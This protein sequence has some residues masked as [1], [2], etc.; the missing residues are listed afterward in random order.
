M[1]VVTSIRIHANACIE[2][3][4]DI[5]MQLVN[6]KVSVIASLENAQSV[7]RRSVVQR[8]EKHLHTRLMQ[9]LPPGCPP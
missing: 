3:Y 6:E 5:R 4:S 8:I 9:L 7:P 1:H 2:A